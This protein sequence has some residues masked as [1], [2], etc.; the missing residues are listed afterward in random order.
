[1]HDNVTRSFSFDFLFFWN[2]LHFYL[3]FLN[4]QMH[5]FLNSYYRNN[6]RVNKKLVPQSAVLNQVRE[7]IIRLCCKASGWTRLGA[8]LCCLLIIAASLS[9]CDMYS[10]CKSP[11]SACESPAEVT[12]PAI[13]CCQEEWGRGW[14]GRGS[15]VQV[16]SAE[17][18]GRH[19]QGHARGHV[20]GSGWVTR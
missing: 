20:C 1:M 4:L 17:S 16:P 12:C 10:S 8:V 13:S 3:F 19:I 15:L 5:E 18:G 11:L 7:V 6:L 14:V 9:S 2:Y